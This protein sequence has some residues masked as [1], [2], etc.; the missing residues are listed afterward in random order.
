M[1]P[2][3]ASVRETGAFALR[4]PKDHGG[5]WETATVIAQTLAEL[6]RSDPAAAWVAGTCL[7]GKTLAARSFGPAGAER[8]FAD[9]DSLFCGSGSPT[10]RGEPGPDGIRLTGRWA[11]I[12]GCL[13]ADWA[14]LGAL[15]GGTFSLV[16]VPLTDLTIDRTWD[17]AGMR[18]TESHSVVAADVLVPADLVAPLRLPG[19]PADM[20]LFGLSVL[21][22]VVGATFGALDLIDAMFASDRKPY[23]T[24]YASMGESPG[25]RH[26]LAQATHLAGRA[27]RT[28]LA[29]A[30]GAP[31][32]GM[33]LADAARDCRSAVDLM[34]DLHGASG[35]AMANPLQ[36]FWRDVAVG[37]RH[38]H[39]N[40]YL[41]VER[42]TVPSGS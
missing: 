37:S 28:M 30:E 4:T 10:G 15:V 3:L 22:P 32:T 17:M 35:F 36:R 13:D 1:N 6:G 18:D 7:T 24:S 16:A 11:N 2:T 21:A 8:V 26:W 27:E 38:P 25:A 9:P 5:S 34:L 41:A 23:L 20:T 39:L 12:S 19:D 42:F 14:V 40:P 31:G 29:V 33:E